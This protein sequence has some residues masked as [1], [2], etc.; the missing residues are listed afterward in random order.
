MTNTLKGI[1]KI[2]LNHVKNKSNKLLLNVYKKNTRAIS[3][4]QREGFEIQCSGFD[5]ATG[6]EDYLMAWQQK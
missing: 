1:G 3:F 4:Y 5:K 2:L 6:E